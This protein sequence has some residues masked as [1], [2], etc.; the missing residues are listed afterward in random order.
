MDRREDGEVVGQEP[1]FP[2]VVY[3]IA[4]L[5]EGEA[6]CCGFRIGEDGV[7]EIEL[8]VE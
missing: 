6:P 2:G 5:A 1:L 4:S 7:T 3:L 8:T